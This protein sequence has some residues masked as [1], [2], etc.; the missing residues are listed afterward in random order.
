MNALD[1]SYCRSVTDSG[2]SHL[3]RCTNLTRLDCSHTQ[4]TSD[5]LAKF[6]S[7]SKHKLKLYGSVVDRRQS[8]R[9]KK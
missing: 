6:V 3:H 7:S 9:S 8:S 2:L 5:G 1:L 4:M